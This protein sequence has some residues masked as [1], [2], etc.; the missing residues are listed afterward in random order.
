MAPASSARAC[1]W[2]CARGYEVRA[3]TRA[4]A[5][6]EGIAGSTA[7]STGRSLEQLGEGADAVIHVAGVLNARDAAGFEAGNVEGTAD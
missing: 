6:P 7:R 1:C 4:R 2:L 3:L 5:P